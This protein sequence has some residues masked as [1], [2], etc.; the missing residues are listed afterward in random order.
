[1][2]LKINVKMQLLVPSGTKVIRNDEWLTLV[3]KSGDLYRLLTIHIDDVSGYD[4]LK[5]DNWNQFNKSE[6][7]AILR[8]K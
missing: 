8:I 4:F 7:Y 5:E 2:K 6:L 1:M 3:R